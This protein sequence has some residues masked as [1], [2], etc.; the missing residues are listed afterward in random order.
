MKKLGVS[1]ST[2]FRKKWRK[3]KTTKFQQ[4]QQKKK[5]LINKNE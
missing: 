3:T 1:Y 5:A 4:Q 2:N